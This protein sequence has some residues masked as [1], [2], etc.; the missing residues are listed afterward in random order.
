MMIA[1]DFVTMIRWTNAAMALI[2][3]VWMGLRMAHRW[4]H[5]P[6]QFRLFYLTLSF[7]V[8]GVLEGTLEGLFD[9]APQHLRVVINLMANLALLTTL[10]LTQPTT[11]VE[12]DL[13]DGR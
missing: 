8:F 1:D 12:M 6:Y 3:L 9:H 10:A 13:R 4:A 5:Y 2:S 11:Y 7:F